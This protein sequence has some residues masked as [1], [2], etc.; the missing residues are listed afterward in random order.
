VFVEPFPH[1][2]CRVGQPGCKPLE[3]RLAGI[4]RT[5]VT[6]GITA[7]ELSNRKQMSVD[8]GALT[9][10]VHAVAWL[11]APDDRHH[12]QLQYTFTVK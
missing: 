6:C 1:K 11:A 12:T 10:G 7:V 9:E 4:P 3:N 8:L 5:S 2:S